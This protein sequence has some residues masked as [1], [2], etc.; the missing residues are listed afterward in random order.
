MSTIALPIRS[1]VSLVPADLLRLRKRRGLVAV[2]TLLTVG[3]VVVSNTIVEILHLSNAAAHGPAGGV[4]MLGHQAWVIGTLGAVAAAIVGS[5]AAVGDLEAGVYRDLVLTGRSRAALYLSRIPAGLLFVV[6]FVVAATA[7]EA[8]VSVVLAGSNPTPSSSL[9]ITTGLWILLKV[10][11][12]YAVAFGIASY[13]GSRAYAIGIVLGW[14]L[15]ISPF[16]S[17]L[18]TLGVTRELLSSV[19]IQSLT[20]SALGTAASQGPVIGMSLGAA[21]AVLAAW[22]IVPLVAGGLRD[23]RRDA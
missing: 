23:S 19:A 5:A 7:V 17:T 21:I 3:A 2:I 18:S 8:V 1:F 16:L 15:A 12:S 13:T 9:L 22:T 20:P 6:P 10:A 11:V 4:T 14:T